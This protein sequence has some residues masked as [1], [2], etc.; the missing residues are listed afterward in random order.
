MR[1][2]LVV[3]LCAG[4]LACDSKSSDGGQ[5][6][7]P[8][9]GGQGEIPKNG[10]IG[11]VTDLAGAAVAG[12]AVTGGGATATTGANGVYTLDAAPGELV[13]Q[14]DKAGYVHGIKST[15]VAAGSAS[16]LDATMA[17][18][19]TAKPLDATAGGTVEADR[20]AKV[21]VPAGA[22][23]DKA[24]VAVTGQVDVHLT[25]LDPSVPA[26][27]AAYPGDLRALDKG[28]AAVQLESFGVLDVTIRKD[29]EK[30]EVK[31][32]MTLSIVVP[33]PAGVTDRPDTVGLWSFDDGKGLW[34]EE[35]AAT[36][37]AAD[38]AYHAEIPHMSPWNCDQPMETTCLRG[39]VIDETGAAVAGAQVIATG[40]DYAGQSSAVTDAD[41]QY[42]V[43]V[44]LSS[45]VRVTA[46]HPG[47]G[48]AQIEVSSDATNVPV[49]PQCDLCKDIGTLTVSAG[50]VTGPGG[51]TVDCA[52]LP[53]PFAGTCGEGMNELFTCYAP[54]GSCVI[55]T[56]GVGGS[57]IEYENG[58]KVVSSFS[59]EGTGGTFYGPTGAVCGTYQVQG[60]TAADAAIAYTTASG[61]SFRFEQRDTGWAVVCPSGEEVAI[62]SAEADAY[63]ACSGGQTGST[64]QC[65]QEG[66]GAGGGQCTKDADCGD[67]K[68]CCTTAAGAL[69]LTAEQCKD[70][71]GC[72]TSA[73]C[74]GDVCCT[75]GGGQVCMSQDDCDKVCTS[76][77]Q[78]EGGD[79][80]CSFGGA[81]KM[82][83]PEAECPSTPKCASDA[84]CA[85]GSKCCTVSGYVLCIPTA[86]CP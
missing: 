83:G 29:G 12:V 9:G 32:G 60:T 26:E 61:S 5:S 34:I 82:C 72:K 77:A 31:D 64:S 70:A 62:S 2:L 58:S 42:C 16:R 44:R 81:L 33:A 68:Q 14:F 56:S 37:V 27:L 69:C 35:G 46:V 3:L 73:D 74:D 80:C 55:R 39:K 4:A 22:L 21:T 17:K 19:A 30:L 10:L 15:T 79:I 54:S 65:T 78:C 13:I 52:D 53:N 41:G 7:V 23:V 6:T 25:P 28:G 59:G 67:G 47:G 50:V 11:K 45:S 51:D 49:P 1:G 76:D 85:D 38:G 71:G 8:G 66:G 40:T 24:G 57:E 20:G 36:Y 43:P 86:T 18:E 84:D 48:G 75:A 63:S